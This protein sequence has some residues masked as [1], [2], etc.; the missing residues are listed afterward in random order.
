VIC[1]STQQPTAGNTKRI[2]IRVHGTVQGVNFRYLAR[3]RARSLGL[4]GWV[5]N[6][7]DG[8]VEAVAEGPDKGVD[9]FASWMRIGPSSARVQQA[10]VEPESSDESFTGFEIR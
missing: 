8:S 7:D 4:M 10:E 5:R 6:R 9:E 3:H 1:A 2:R